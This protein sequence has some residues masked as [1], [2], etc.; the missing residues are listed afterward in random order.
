MMLGIC[1]IG[2]IMIKNNNLRQWLALNQ[3][4]TY[5]PAAIYHLVQQ[6][7]EQNIDVFSL[8]SSELVNQGF[9]EKIVTQLQKIDWS[10]V[11]DELDWAAQKNHR[12]ITVQDV[13]YPALLREIDMPPLLLYV[14]GQVDYLNQ[15]QLAMVGSRNPTP[16][17]EEI[18]QRFSQYLAK[19]GLII[20]S[21]LAVG[22]D[23][24]SHKGAMATGQTIA[25]LG[26]GLKHIYPMIHQGLAEQIM[27]YGAVISEFPLKTQPR[28]ENFPRRNR[29]IS[30]LSL[31]VLVVE[32]ALQSGSLITAR[33]A[34]EQGREVFAIPGSIHNPLSK[35][36]HHLIRKGAK[37]VETAQ[38]IIEELDALV[39]FVASK[40]TSQIKQTKQEK[41]EED[42]SEKINLFNFD[43]DDDYVKLLSCVGY[44]PTTVDAIILR[45]NFSPKVVSSMLL[46]LELQGFVKSGPR[47]Y[48]RLQER[49][50]R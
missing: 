4:Y 46:S 11:D 16:I 7:I 15:W 42:S 40:Q 29:V 24:A 45:S 47:G 9:P 28:R 14:A 19:K 3:L 35:G 48:C 6:T 36:C 32:A 1:I 37:L 20:T 17:G 21:G 12:V 34:N 25:V 41:K 5:H 30:G 43:S 38:D 23:A 26:S 39:E 49:K 33:F 50:E 10:I 8:S 22:I 18:A 2:F 27:E 13:S 44:E 31:G